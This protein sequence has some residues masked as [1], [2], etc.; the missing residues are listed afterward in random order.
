MINFGHMQLAI[1]A[2]LS[3]GLHAQKDYRVIDQTYFWKII[4]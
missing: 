3:F 1:S 4:M 2:N